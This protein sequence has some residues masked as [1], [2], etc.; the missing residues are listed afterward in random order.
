MRTPIAQALA[1]PERIDSGVAPIDLIQ[2]GQL[3]FRQPDMLQFPCLQLAYDALAAGGS[4]AALMNAARD[5]LS[6]IGEPALQFPLTPEQLW[7][8][9][10]TNQPKEKS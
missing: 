10:H 9:M 3:S 8:A 2:I 1:Y 5:A 6:P 4:P 7:R